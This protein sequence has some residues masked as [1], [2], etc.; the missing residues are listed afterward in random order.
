MHYIRVK[1][2]VFTAI[3]ISLT[4]IFT[5]V[6]AIQTPFIRISFGFLPVALFAML[7]GPIKGACMAAL[8]DLLGCLIFSPG[9]YFPGFTVSAF[10]S[11]LIYGYFFYNKKITLTKIIFVSSIIFILIDLFL[12]T[13]WLCAL[14]QKA[15]QVF[16]LSR[17]IKGAILL[18]IQ[19]SIIYTVYKAVYHHK[20]SD[21]IHT[22][23]SFF[24]S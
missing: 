21:V 5:H 12:N 22:K 2:I 9:L 20:I 6:F 4:V 8:A 24:N 1:T 11:G 16:F 7:F 18:P 15:A 23:N 19:I 13:L 3:F 17:F 14:Y 10:L